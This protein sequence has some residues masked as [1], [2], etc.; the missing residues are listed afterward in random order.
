MSFAVIDI[1]GF[2]TPDFIPKELA[3]WDG[4]RLG[5]YVFKEPFPFKYLS[6]PLQRQAIWL[7]N[8]YQLHWHIGDVEISRIPHILDNVKQYAKT[9]HCK[10]KIKKEYLLK[11]LGP[12]TII[13]DWDQT[14]NLHNLPRNQYKF[15]NTDCFNHSAGVCAAKNVK[16]LYDYILTQNG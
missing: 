6:E 4:Q 10:G 15:E 16:L 3:I 9:V 5:H 2:L 12:P 13:I 14:P 11:F 8:N 7:T 1:Q